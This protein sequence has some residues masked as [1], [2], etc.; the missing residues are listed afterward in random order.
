MDA[1]MFGGQGTPQAPTPR[2]T[3]ETRWTNNYRVHL[4]GWP[5]VS[6][7]F[8]VRNSRG[9]IS[10]PALSSIVNRDTY[11]YSFNGA[12]N[13]VLRLGRNS[14]SFSGGLQYTLRRDRRSPLEMNQNL[15]RQFLYFSTNS[16]FNWFSIQGYG[17]HESGPFLNRNARSR[18]LSG[19][20]EFRVGR[21]WGNTALVTGYWARDLLFRPLIREWFS[22]SSYIGI[23]R[24]FGESLSLRAV[25][26]YIRGWRVQDLDYVLGQAIRPALDFSYKP[27][28]RWSID[29]NVS[30]S[31]GMGIRDYD[32][33][34]SGV[35]VSYVRPLR[36]VHEDGGE[37]V[38]IEYP[39]RFSVGMQQQQFYNFAGGRQSTYLPIVRLT[40]F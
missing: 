26:E 27:A 19:R 30:F 7:F 38:P 4:E 13:P 1:R 28:R 25:A 10:F 17:T 6:G 16:F 8:Q 31:R 37:E 33:V 40:I 3:L 23:E 20:L 35:Y 2:H 12:L 39:L 36:R 18:D 32:N 34:M 21:P 29:G 15:F 24:R 11:D 14:V 22:T 5:T 9:Q